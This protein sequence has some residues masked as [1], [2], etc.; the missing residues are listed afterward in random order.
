MKATDKIAG[1]YNAIPM[2]KTLKTAILLTVTVS[3]FAGAGY[4]GY[5]GIKGIIVKFK[6]KPKEEKQL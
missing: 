6:D 2:N 1:W 3:V 5:K 4:L